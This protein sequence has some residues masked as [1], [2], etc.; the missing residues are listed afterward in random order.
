M[1]WNIKSRFGVKNGRRVLRA[2]EGQ[3]TDLLLN[4]ENIVQ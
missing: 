2:I 1:K 3:M 4:L